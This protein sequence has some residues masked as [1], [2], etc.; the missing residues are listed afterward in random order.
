MSGVSVPGLSSGRSRP[1]PAAP[2]RHQ[3]VGGRVRP[4]PRVRLPWRHPG[5]AVRPGLGPDGQQ[6]PPRRASRTYAHMRES[7]PFFDDYWQG[8][9]AD[10]APSTSPPTSSPAGPTTACTHAGPSRASA[11]RSRL[12]TSGS[13]STAARSGR[14]ST[15]TRSVARQTAFFDRY[16]KDHPNQVDTWP[17]VRLEIRERANTGN[18]GTSRMAA[19]ADP[20]HQLYLGRQHEPLPHRRCLTGSRV[21]YLPGDRRPRRL[22]LTP[23][24]PTPNSIG[25]MKLRLWVEA[26][27]PTTWTYSSA[28][29][30]STSTANA[31]PSRSSPHSTTATSRS[32]WLR[33]AAAEL[34]EA[35]STPEQPVTASSKISCWQ[36]GEV[37]PVEVEIWPSGTRFR[38]GEALRLVIQGHDLHTY[39]ENAFAQRHA[40]TANA[41]RHVLHTGGRVRLAPPDPGDPRL[42]ARSAVQLSLDVP[43]VRGAGL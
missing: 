24:T 43:E 11:R 1:E 14:T 26:T 22:R 42:T 30:N 15:T 10:L 16:L 12:R 20:L 8:K 37:V 6:Q 2:R 38:A 40:W 36:P 7:H 4:V 41:G 39:P 29:R 18:P 25:Y 35:G 5:H 34:D 28:F 3:P 21:A 17:P 23:S 13:K 33:V 19:R 27:T 31:S 32:G 9:D